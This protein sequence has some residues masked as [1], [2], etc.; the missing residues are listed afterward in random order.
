MEILIVKPFAYHISFYG[1]TFILVRFI[2]NINFFS[3]LYVKGM[4]MVA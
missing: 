4:E 3:S 1:S 2:L